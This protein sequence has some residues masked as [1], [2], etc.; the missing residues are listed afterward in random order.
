VAVTVGGSALDSST[1]AT[2][3]G[4]S[5]ACAGSDSAHEGY[6]RG[7]EGTTRTLWVQRFRGARLSTLVSTNLREDRRHV[8]KQRKSE[9]L[10]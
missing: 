8:S 2:T 7:S 3:A 5:S 1:A 6:E 9:N 10:Q 4:P